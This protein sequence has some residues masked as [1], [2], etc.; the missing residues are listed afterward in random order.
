MRS[1][2]KIGQRVRF[3]LK[4]DRKRYGEFGSVVDEF[5]TVAG[6]IYGIRPDQDTR[7]VA[8]THFRRLRN[9]S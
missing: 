5:T 1:E 8:D 6:R 2:F 7:I 9:A 3:T 4:A